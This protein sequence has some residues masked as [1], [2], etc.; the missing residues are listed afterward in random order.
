MSWL[1]SMR[2]SPIF[3]EP[4]AIRLLMAINP[5][6]VFLSADE[7]LVVYDNS[8]DTLYAYTFDGNLIGTIKHISAV[9]KWQDHII[10]YSAEEG[11]IIILN[12]N[13]EKEDEIKVDVP[14]IP[15]HIALTAD[16]YMVC[17]D[18]ECRLFNA[19]EGKAKRF[20][21]K[22]PVT[23]IAG[24][25]SFFAIGREEGW[26]TIVD[27][28]IV[29]TSHKLPRGYSAENF[30]VA[31]PTTVKA[32]GNKAIA[33]SF[34]GVAHI[35]DAKIIYDAEISDDL[36]IDVSVDD[37]HFYHLIHTLDNDEGYVI[38]T[39][40]RVYLDDNFF[41]PVIEDLYYP[42]IGLSID[43]SPKYLAIM[44]LQAVA[45]LDKSSW[46]RV[47]NIPLTQIAK[48]EKARFFVNLANN[49]PYNL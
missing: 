41:D 9:N 37:E 6:K 40:T 28:S 10:V 36:L 15:K 47:A 14:F 43:V 11:K 35:Q 16:G 20:E 32:K 17:M 39:S 33:S 27:K 46:Q 19:G 44:Y 25:D 49:V 7:T 42:D 5:L 31:Y 22:Q 34:T 4:S 24:S 2:W 48:S 3:L 12:G 1:R 8:V 38:I 23:S 13:L 45:I 26:V 30:T 21:F 29:L 18:K